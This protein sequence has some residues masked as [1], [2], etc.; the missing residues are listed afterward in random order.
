MQAKIN[1]TKSGTV[2][3]LNT[4]DDLEFISDDYSINS[5]KNTI[6]RFEELKDFN[7]FFVKINNGEYEEVYGIYGTVP[8]ITKDIYRIEVY[9]IP[10]IQDKSQ[11]NAAKYINTKYQD[12]PDY[13]K[14]RL[15]DYINSD[16]YEYDID[17]Y[18]SYTDPIDDYY[19][20][21]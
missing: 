5:I 21:L 14:S 19:N 17:Y 7:S 12:Q 3:D 4:R 8:Y 6:G 11:F 1:I 16:Q 13:I 18:G 2:K 10:D 15:E 20:S 9:L